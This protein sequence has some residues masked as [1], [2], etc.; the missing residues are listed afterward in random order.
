MSRPWFWFRGFYCQLFTGRTPA[1]QSACSSLL[2]CGLRLQIHPPDLVLGV[3]SAGAGCFHIDRLGV[4]RERSHDKHLGGKIQGSGRSSG[5]SLPFQALPCTEP[6]CGSSRTEPTHHCSPSLVTG[7]YRA[8]QIFL[9]SPR[10]MVPDLH[11][12]S[13][14]SRQV[15]ARIASGAL[16]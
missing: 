14:E 9:L 6:Y 7:S 4:A 16:Q 5:V 12:F 2:L 15:V 3:C 11:S 1:F 13:R 10:N 8:I